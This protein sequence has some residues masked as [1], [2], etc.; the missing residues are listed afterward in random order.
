MSRSERPCPPSSPRR[1]SRHRNVELLFIMAFHTLALLFLA[2]FAGGFIDA[3]AGGGGLITVPALLA[4]GLPPQLALGTN[5]FQSSFG[6]IITV[7]RYARAGLINTPFLW[8]AAALS[9]LASMAGAFAV[10]MM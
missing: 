2:G 6:T 10:S 4:S 5:K 3:I 9:F 1:P 7:L 8:L